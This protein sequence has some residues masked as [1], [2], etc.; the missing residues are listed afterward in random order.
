M[1]Y[2]ITPNAPIYIYALKDPFTDEIRYIGKTI[3]LKRRLSNECRETAKSYRCHWIQSII[4]RGKKPIQVILETLEPDADW[5]A[6][7]K[8]WIAYGRAQGW[9]LTNTTEG[10][11][12]VPGISGESK[13][14]MLKA[15]K[16]RKHKPES[17]VKIGLASK[18][19]YQSEETKRKR[20]EAL[21]GR[22]FSDETRSKISANVSKL[23]DVQI[24]QIRDLLSNKVSQRV[25]AKM[26]G[27]HQTTISNINRGKCYVD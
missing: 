13:E 4:S 24:E 1:S 25:I 23:T 17:L 7:E 27:V 9:P 18:G 19:R 15:W 8:K 12:G 5:Q 14:R 2:C 22:Q 6:A 20:S 16:G 3:N 21:K 26:F 11:D 10:G